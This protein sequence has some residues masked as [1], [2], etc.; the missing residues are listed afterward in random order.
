MTD[1]IQ[2]FEKTLPL[3][4]TDADGFAKRLKNIDWDGA[5]DR[6]QALL[7]AAL[8]AVRSAEREIARQKARI[9]KLESLSMTDENTGLLN[10][11]GFQRELTRAL[12]AAR[13][14]S[15]K[16]ILVICDLDGF[17]NINDTYGHAAGDAVIAQIAKLLQ[18]NVRESDSVA[19]L[20]G[21]EF[22]IL[23]IDTDEE[24]ATK[25]AQELNQIVNNF[26]VGWNGNKIP[27]RASFGVACIDP[28]VTASQ[29][30]HNADLAMYE[31]KRNNHIKT[32]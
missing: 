17:K 26:V 25:R 4:K 27:A 28:Q 30:Y 22:A 7:R 24:K 9:Q 3:L 21:D 8:M 20:G 2:E 5:E 31:H 15:Q 12:S 13:R 6:D 14:K 29:L 10:R 11:R 16:G 18:E 1:M 23:M 19:R 32:A